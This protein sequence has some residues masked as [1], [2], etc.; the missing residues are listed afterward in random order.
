[1]SDND[2]M[3]ICDGCGE[4]TAT[5]RC[6]GCR[7]VWYCSKQCQNDLWTWHIFE[8]GPRRSIPTAYHL[9]KAVYDD[10]LPTDP[11]TNKE[12]GLDKA[13]S[14]DPS[15]PFKIFGLYVDLIKICD[16]KP[17]QL[18]KWR[19][20]GTLIQEIKAIYEATPL[21]ARGGYYPWFL[22]HQEVLENPMV[23]ASEWKSMAEAMKRRAWVA[24]GNSATASSTAIDEFVQ[25]LSKEQIDC[26]VLYAMLQSSG[27]PGPD[28][29]LYV[30][31]GFCTCPALY[32][33]IQLAGAYQ[34]LFAASTFDEV[35]EAY[36]AGTLF[37][38]FQTKNV[39]MGRVRCDL[40]ADALEGRP[41]S[42]KSVWTLKKFVASG[43]NGSPSLAVTFDYGFINSAGNVETRKQ[44]LGLYK[45]YFEL[46]RANPLELHA[47]CV[48]G[49][50]FRFFTEDMQ[51]TLP[52]DPGL[53][54]RLL[55]NMN[56]LQEH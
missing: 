30:P 16:V 49:R 4:S 27:H 14:I 40:L 56:P 5:A 23:S 10:L 18:H 47:A 22:E 42:H 37:R 29:D 12:W 17:Q 7:K 55:K 34:A 54:G 1:M 11:Q 26:F 45:A 28:T 20:Q 43:G 9:A 38:L 6:A 36:S 21:H 8:C 35:C 2:N 19:V 15:G 50:L 31:F 33:E 48:E 13:A 39:S 44:L 51:M 46:S 52:G 32:D 24:L 3:H 41:S 53:F 25:S